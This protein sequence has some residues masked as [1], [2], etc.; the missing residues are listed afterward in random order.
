MEF[1]NIYCD[2]SCHLRTQ[3]GPM[4]LGAVKMK[5]SSRFVHRDAIRQIKQKHGIN[6]C[7]EM[8]WTR[9][10]N[11]KA[12][13]YCDLVRYFFQADGLTYRALIAKK[14]GLRPEEFGMTYD[15]WY[16]KMYYYLLTPMISSETPTQ[17]YLDIKDTH[18]A[19]K[20]ARLQ[21]V[22]CN[23]EL[24]FD[25]SLIRRVQEIRSHELE[26]MSV[27]D[28]LNG[29][30]SYFHRGLATSRAKRRVID[31]IIKLSQKSLDRT[32]LFSAKKFNL[33]IWKKRNV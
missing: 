24:D 18:G 10:S 30:L 2:E 17:I 22:L 16:Y 32:T 26:I 31:T 23:K 12:D 3:D 19:R 20:V 15:D 4:I 5:W 25:H 14:E 13:A 8:K 1:N 28:V 6:P 21:E 11:A 7:A 29:A 9:I 33:F 27:V